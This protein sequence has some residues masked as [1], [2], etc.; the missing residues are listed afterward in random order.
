MKYIPTLVWSPVAPLWIL[1]IR[2]L[3]LASVPIPL[4]PAPGP[5]TPL[6]STLTLYPI[7]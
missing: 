4:V 1:G 2:P 6:F 5:L 3:H 7:Y